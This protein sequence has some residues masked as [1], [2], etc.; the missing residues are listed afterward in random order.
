MRPRL[1][2]VIRD[3]IEK[4]GYDVVINKQSTIYAKPELDITAKVVELLNKQ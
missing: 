4:G 1:D 3:M 2:A